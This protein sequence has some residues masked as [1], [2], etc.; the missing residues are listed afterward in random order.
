MTAKATA[1]G[2]TVK[3]TSSKKHSG[4]TK[5]RQ[6]HH[7]KPATAKATGHKVTTKAKHATHAKATGLAVGDWLPVCAFE[8]V[9]Q[10]LRL[11]GQPV[12]GDEVAELWHLLGERP[13]GVPVGEALAAAA[14]FGLAGYRP[15]FAPFLPQFLPRVDQ[16]TPALPQGGREGNDV[17]AGKESADCP[18]DLGPAHG[19]ILRIDVPGP[20]AVLAT[21]S[22]WWSWGELHAPWPCRVSEAWAVSWTDEKTARGLSPLV[23]AARAGSGQRGWP[24]PSLAGDAT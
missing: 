13:E 4:T 24:V 7:R 21:A 8:A 14:L 22:G 10:S 12:H 3:H 20:H 19:L 16:V 17:H 2:H 9:A 23:L 11:A 1:S 18:A 15:R 5:H 6:N